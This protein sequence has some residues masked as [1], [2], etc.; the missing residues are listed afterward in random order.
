MIAAEWQI[1]FPFISRHKILTFKFW[2]PTLNRCRGWQ[3]AGSWQQVC[4]YSRAWGGTENRSG[5]LE[6]KT[7]NKCLRLISQ[8]NLS[9]LPTGYHQRTSAC[10]F[11]LAPLRGERPYPHLHPAGN[12]IY[13]MALLKI[14]GA[15]QWSGPSPEKGIFPAAYGVPERRR[16][17]NS[18][19]KRRLFEDLMWFLLTVMWNGSCICSITYKNQSQYVCCFKLILLSLST[20]LLYKNEKGEGGGRGDRS[21]PKTAGLQTRAAP[22]RQ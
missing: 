4:R 8:P 2:V 10:C 15:R 7:R 16:A 18:L 17:G 20:L 1:L 11:S 6:L 14:K 12:P 19:S 9:S 13:R 21:W 3:A 5:W 22:R